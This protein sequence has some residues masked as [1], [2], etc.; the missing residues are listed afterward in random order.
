M[1]KSIAKLNCQIELSPLTP[2][3]RPNLFHGRVSARFRITAAGR[4]VDEGGRD[5]EPTGYI[6]FLGHDD[7]APNGP[8]EYRARFV[9]GALKS[10]VRIGDP[11]DRIYGLESIRWF[12][13]GR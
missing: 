2:G 9:E 13:P 10:I 4:L 3:S 6:D 11:D 7:D 5:L 8:V 12:N 1:T